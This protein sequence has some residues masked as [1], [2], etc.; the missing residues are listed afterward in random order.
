MDMKL[1]KSLP[2]IGLLV[3][4]M[5][6]V[7]AFACPGGPG[8]PG[9]GW[10]QD[11]QQAMQQR[12]AEELNLSKE[13]MRHFK[14]IHEDARDAMQANRDAMRANRDAMRSLDPSAADYMAKVSKLAAEKG[15]LVEEM[16]MQRA[17]LR[18]QTAAILTPEQL[19]RHEQLRKERWENWK[20]RRSDRRGMGRGNGMGRGGPDGD[21]GPR[22]W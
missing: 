13:Q 17:R 7:P 8:G 19:A 6:A 1:N 11:R 9:G 21:R 3:A 5:L 15:K 22:G 10:S 20:E 16:M 12:M 14:T 4:T 2:A 18:A